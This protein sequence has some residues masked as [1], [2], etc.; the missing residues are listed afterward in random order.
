MHGQLHQD[1]QKAAST[2]Y[3]WRVGSVR[4]AVGGA[5]ADTAACVSTDAAAITATKTDAP[6]ASLDPF[7]PGCGVG[8]VASHDIREGE[9]LLVS[10]ALFPPLS[11]FNRTQPPSGLDLANHMSSQQPVFSPET[12]QWLRL[13]H[14]GSSGDAVGDHTDDSQSRFWPQHEGSI[15]D[16]GQQT[17]SRLS[18]LE[19]LL[20]SSIGYEDGNDGTVSHSEVRLIGGGS[21]E[22]FY[23]S[24]SDACFLA[25]AS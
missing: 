21:T 2:K 10:P 25:L 11:G 23:A 1:A 22:M 4:A 7:L 17:H 19:R 5:T 24:L 9:V 13:L 8:F 16:N 14:V 20:P 18:R 3:H 12:Q 15:A 6:N